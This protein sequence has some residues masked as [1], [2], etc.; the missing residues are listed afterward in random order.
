MKTFFSALLLLIPM[1]V[2]A[3]ATEDSDSRFQEGTHY[4]VINGLPAGSKPTVTELFSVYCGS[5]YQW[6]YGPLNTLKS[7]LNQQNIDFQQA[8]MDFM[9]GYAKQASTALAITQ[10]TPRFSAVKKELFNRIHTE[11]KGDWK[12][13][14]EFFQSLESAGL[15]EADFNMMKSS[16]SV[17]MKLMEWHRY[18]EHVHAVPSFMVNN[19]YLVNMSSLKS[20]DDL[21]SLITYLTSLPVPTGLQNATQR[22][23]ER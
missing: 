9:G 18:G 4:T 2:F 8:H 5:C 7:W 19:R 13:N 22:Y 17:G 3:Q 23:N 20:Y 16:L 11:R 14:N 10:G 6:E 12:S 1:M 21:N 15:T